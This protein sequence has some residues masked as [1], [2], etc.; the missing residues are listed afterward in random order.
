MPLD[1]IVCNQVGHLTRYAI[2]SICR[3]RK[4]QAST[5]AGISESNP[6]KLHGRLSRRVLPTSVYPNLFYN[7]VAVAVVKKS[8]NGAFIKH[9]A[10]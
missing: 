5:G 8:G 6:N 1:F 3:I 4:N 2:A 10:I 9:D 7:Q